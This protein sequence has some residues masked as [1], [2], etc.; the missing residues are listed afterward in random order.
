MP[1][2]NTYFAT[3]VVTLDTKNG[4]FAMS[5]LAQILYLTAMLLLATRLSQAA[6]TPENA[7]PQLNR[8]ALARLLE[9]QDRCPRQQV[10][11]YLDACQERAAAPEA[12]SEWFGVLA[13]RRAEVDQL[14]LA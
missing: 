3:H 13:Q 5:R 12:A 4:G 7:P 11:E 14:E 9:T 2:R 10:R 8:D 6:C 1:S